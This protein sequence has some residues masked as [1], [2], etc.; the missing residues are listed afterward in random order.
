MNTMNMNT[1]G[2]HSLDWFEVDHQQTGCRRLS[3]LLTFWESPNVCESHPINNT[4]NNSSAPFVGVH[5]V[6]IQWDVQQYEA[7]EVPLWSE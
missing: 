5:P 3:R 6:S 4:N 2:A 1:L 7:V